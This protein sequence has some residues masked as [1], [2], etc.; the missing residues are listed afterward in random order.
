M[1]SQVCILFGRPKDANLILISFLGTEPF[2]ANDWG[3][4][5]FDYSRAQISNMVMKDLDHYHRKIDSDV[6]ENEWDQFSASEEGPAGG[7]KKFQPEMVKETA[8]LRAVL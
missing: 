5:D 8:S 7:Q 6:D 4:T 2:D 3:G 1:S